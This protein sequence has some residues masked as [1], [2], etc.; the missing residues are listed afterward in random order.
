MMN[1]DWGL[2]SMEGKRGEEQ[3]HFGMGFGWA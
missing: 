3:E 1:G 2:E